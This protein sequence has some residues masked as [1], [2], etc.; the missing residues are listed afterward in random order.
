MIVD[1]ILVNTPEYV[2][3]TLV[4]FDTGVVKGKGRICG[5]ASSEFPV[6]GYM[7]IVDVI[8]STPPIPNSEYP[9]SCFVV[10]SSLLKED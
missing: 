1:G 7:W 9:Y 6:I 4:T 8:E 2:E 10:Q 5:K 3:G